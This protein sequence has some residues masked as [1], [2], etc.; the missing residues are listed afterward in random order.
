MTRH[1][2]TFYSPGTFFAESTTKPIKSWDVELAKKMA[3]DIT[4]RYDAKPYGFRFETHSRGKNDLNAKITKTS[5]TY[6]LS[7]TVE[8]LAQVKARATE[9][10]QILVRNMEGNGWKR[11]ITSNT[12]WR[13]SQPLYP[14]DVV[15]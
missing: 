5:G 12:P 3:D 15:L 9:A 10:D 4:E 13:W 8:T 6:Y 7:G 11:I 1:F 2:V 14:E